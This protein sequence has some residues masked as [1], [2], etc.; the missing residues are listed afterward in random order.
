MEISRRYVGCNAIRCIAHT[1]SGL[2][3]KLRLEGPMYRDKLYQS[4]LRSISLHLLL[5]VIT[6]SSYSIRPNIKVPTRIYLGYTVNNI[7][8][9]N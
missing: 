5:L 6:S 4:P 8:L 9:S 2:K 3:K 7:C 1:L